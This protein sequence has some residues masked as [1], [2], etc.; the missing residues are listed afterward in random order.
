MAFEPKDMTFSL[1]PNKDKK[2][3]KHPN[4]TGTAIING[5]AYFI[6]GWTNVDRNGNKYIAGKMKPKQQASN[7]GTGYSNTADPVPV[8]RRELDDEIPF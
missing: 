6:D 1:F 5:A 3:D 4:L 8:N 7:T 2:T